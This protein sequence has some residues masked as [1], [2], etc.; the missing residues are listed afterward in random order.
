MYCGIKGCGR[1]QGARTRRLSD[2]RLQRGRHE[3]GEAGHRG[4][5]GAPAALARGKHEHAEHVRAVAAAR[6][7]VQLL[8]ALLVAAAGDLQREGGGGGRGRVRERMRVKAELR[9]LEDV[10]GTEAV[11]L[12]VDVVAADAFEHLGDLH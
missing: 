12:V 7:G 3:R 5:S 4:A 10:G 11:R 2:N 6:R 1:P 8:V 9:H